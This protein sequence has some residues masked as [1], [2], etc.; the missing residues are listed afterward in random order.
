MELKNCVAKL[1]REDSYVPLADTPMPCSLQQI[2]EMAMELLTSEE[3]SAER[4]LVYMLAQEKAVACTAFTY[5]LARSDVMVLK[6]TVLEGYGLL[7]EAAYA[8]PAERRRLAA[9]AGATC[10][11]LLR[12]NFALQPARRG[13]ARVVASTVQAR[14]LLAY[15]PLEPLRSTALSRSEAEAIVDFAIGLRQAAVSAYLRGVT[16][17]DVLR[18]LEDYVRGASG[19]LQDVMRLAPV[20]DHLYDEVVYTRYYLQRFGQL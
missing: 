1:V 2:R 10:S 13:R 17:A 20:G 11:A 8:P 9:K 12:L 16:P 15:L 3:R 19:W 6:S 14:L 7:R 5:L 4:Q 18:V